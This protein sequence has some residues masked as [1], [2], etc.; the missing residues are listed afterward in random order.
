MDQHIPIRLADSDTAAR[1]PLAVGGE[2]AFEARDGGFAAQIEMPPMRAGDVL[3]P[4]FYGAGIRGYRFSLVS[5]RARTALNPVGEFTNGRTAGPAPVA[6]D[7]QT[8]SADIQT[9]IDYFSFAVDTQPLRLDLEIAADRPPVAHL[10]TVTARPAEIEFDTSATVSVHAGPVRVPALS[11]MGVDGDRRHHICSPTS[12]AMVMAACGRPAPLPAFADACRD[13]QTGL[14]GVWP[15]NLFAA[16]RLGL[17][18]AVETFHDWRDACRVL[19]RGLPLITSIRFAR[20]GL[21]GAPLA[22]T[23]GHLVVLRGVEGDEVLVNDPAAPDAAS[24]P[25]RYRRSE[26]ARAW[27]TYRGA[28]YILCP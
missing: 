2:C 12:V 14:Y 7:T 3:I 26:F 10:L 17:I 4:S 19:D 5:A 16:S 21:T 8:A 6:A 25:R 28:A 13:R 9:H 23:G 11:Q 24:V 20:D 27:L 22:Q 15:V 1:Y 18:G